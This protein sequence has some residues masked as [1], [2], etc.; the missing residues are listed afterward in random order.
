MQKTE[1]SSS[2]AES[3]DCLLWEMDVNI[4]PQLECKNLTLH[5]PTHLRSAKLRNGSKRKEENVAEFAGVKF[6]VASGGGLTCNELQKALCSALS[7]VELMY[8]NNAERFRD[9]LQEIFYYLR[10]AATESVR[11]LIDFSTS[12]QPLSHCI[13]YVLNMRRRILCKG[14]ELP[15]QDFKEWLRLSLLL[16]EPDTL[17]FL[18]DYAQKLGPYGRRYVENALSTYGSS[19]DKLCQVVMDIP[20][21]IGHRVTFDGTYY[22][23]TLND[24]I[25]MGDEGVATARQSSI[26]PHAREGLVE[27]MLFASLSQGLQLETFFLAASILDRYSQKMNI[28]PDY[29][30]VVACAVLLLASKVE[31]RNPFFC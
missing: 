23:L 29:Y 14:F 27:W 26:P 28:K 2:F 17:T 13:S 30:Y 6:P 31:E 9:K 3:S 11:Q 22:N 7:N 21:P 12:N 4:P 24:L 8:A 5:I 18:Q 25:A 20:V 19:L 15:L 10:G 16:R 1:M